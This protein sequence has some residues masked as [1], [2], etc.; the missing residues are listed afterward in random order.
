LVVLGFA[1]ARKPT[2]A[3]SLSSPGASTWSVSKVGADGVEE[4]QVNLEWRIVEM[5]RKRLGLEAP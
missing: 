4:Q 5:E 1:V 3:W 2:R